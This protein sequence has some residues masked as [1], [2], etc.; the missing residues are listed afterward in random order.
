MRGEFEIVMKENTKNKK[1]KESKNTLAKYLSARIALATIIGIIAYVII[2]LFFFAKGVIPPGDGLNKTDWL[3]F[4]GA[5]LSFFGTVLVSLT[6]FW[7]TN[8]V[9]KQS[10][11]KAATERKQRIQPVFSIEI[12]PQNTIMEKHSSFVDMGNKPE[13]PSNVI[14]KIE[15]A[16]EYPITNVIVFDMYIAPLLKPGEE[17][18]V[19]CSYSDPTNTYKFYNSIAVIYE[20]DYEKDISGLPK[21]FNINYDD[22]DGNEMY[23]SF[24]LHHFDET[25]YYSS[26]GATEV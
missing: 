24:V 13:R 10:E 25:P 6:I 4:F 18:S 2:Y 14:I 26:E 19:H 1:R 12:G 23:Q 5:Y 11:E 17:V 3:S 21:W 15:N 20:T 9:S 16:N 22:V 8:Y 7:H